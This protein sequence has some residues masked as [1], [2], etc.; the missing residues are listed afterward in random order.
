MEYFI[1]CCFL[2]FHTEN[3]CLTKFLFLFYYINAKDG[4]MFCLKQ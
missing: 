2:A 1:F 4:G 3:P